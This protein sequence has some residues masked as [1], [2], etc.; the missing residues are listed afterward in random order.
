LVVSSVSP[1]VPPCSSVQQL[2]V[3]DQPKPPKGLRHCYPPFASPPR[4]PPLV[5]LSPQA[6]VIMTHW[7]LAAPPC[8][9]GARPLF[10]YKNYFPLVLFSSGPAFAPLEPILFA[11][12]SGP[13]ASVTLRGPFSPAPTLVQGFFCRPSTTQPP[14]LPPKTLFFQ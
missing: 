1:V 7:L 6:G 13:M 8:L 4:R 2:P 3:I 9:S 11:K 12:L 5:F 14:H 10:V